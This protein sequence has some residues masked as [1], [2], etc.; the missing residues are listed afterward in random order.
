[1]TR[2]LRLNITA[3]FLGM[4]WLC[5]PIGAPLP[6]LMQAMQATSWQLGLLS[7]S[8]QMA[9]LLQIPAAIWA[10]RLNRRKYFWAAV[11]IPH[12][13]LW[14][15]PALIPLLIP[16]R[17]TEWVP[18]IIIALSVSNALANLATAS[19]SSWMAD[20]VPEETAGAFW[21][22][23]QKAISFGLILG[24]S[25]YGWI[26]HQDSGP[27]GIYGFQWVFCLCALF[28]VG[29]ILVHLLALS[30]RI[31]APFRTPGFGILTLAMAFW[32]GAQ[33]LVGYTLALP[34]FF[35]MVHMRSSFGANHAQAACLF[36]AAAFGAGIFS[37]RFGVWMDKAGAAAVLKR[38]VF[39]APV[40][41]LAWWFAWPGET[42]LFGMSIPRAVCWMSVASVAQGGLYVGTFL[43]QMRLTQ[44]HTPVNGRTL[45]MALHWSI[46]GLGGAIGAFAGGWIKGSIETSGMP[47]FLADRYPF[48]ILVFLHV[49]IAWGC[50]YPLCRKLERR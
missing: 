3:G 14:S 32:T 2:S 50:V 24:T 45:A 40:S 44:M 22:A 29:D 9:M 19:W 37:S 48:D 49:L 47:D 25:C 31:L 1:M 4:L 16:E 10:E 6:L 38:L 26:L 30:A 18:W 46:A 36:I 33:A 35:S 13:L 5:V 12:R 42:V 21:S 20:I 11:N 39:W 8:W 15:A 7:A 28:G 41:L 43:C 23:R 34:G 27:G 17:R